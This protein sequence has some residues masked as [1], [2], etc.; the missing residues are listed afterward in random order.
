MEKKK[1]LHGSRHLYRRLNEILFPEQ[2]QIELALIL[3]FTCQK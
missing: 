3:Q 2:Q 1:R